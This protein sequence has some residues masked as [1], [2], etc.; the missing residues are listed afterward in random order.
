MND[1][2]REIACVSKGYGNRRYGTGESMREGE[3]DDVMRKNIFVACEI[4]FHEKCT[5]R[6]NYKGETFTC[7]CECH[8]SDIAAQTINTAAT[9]AT[10]ASQAPD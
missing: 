6:F 8:K 9:S 7:N 2:E 3:G 10:R 5:K 4:G 1:T